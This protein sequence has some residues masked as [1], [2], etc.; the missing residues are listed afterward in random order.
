[1]LSQQGTIDDE[2]LQVKLKVEEEAEAAVVEGRQQIS[3]IAAGFSRAFPC[4][5]RAP[6]RPEDSLE[7]KVN[8]SAGILT[9]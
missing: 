8:F 2:A 6:L 3:R 4:Y 7:L 1:M 9:R 5:R